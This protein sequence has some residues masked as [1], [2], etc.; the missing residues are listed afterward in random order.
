MRYERQRRYRL[1]TNV[2]A[3]Y[4]QHPNLNGI[5]EWGR[6]T[7][8]PEIEGRHRVNHTTILQG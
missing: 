1:R 6:T 2:P 7:Y 3:A 4:R 8:L 5:T